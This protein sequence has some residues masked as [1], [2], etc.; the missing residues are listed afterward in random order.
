MELSEYENI[1]HQED[2]HF[3]YKANHEIII[4]LLELYATKKGKL[5]ILDAGCGT[6]LLAKKLEKFGEVVGVDYHPEAVKLSKSRGVKAKKADVTKLPFKKRG[7]DVV[8]AIDVIY[9]K[10][11]KDDT[12][13]LREFNR[14]LKCGG[15][16]LVRVPANKWL[17]LNHDKYVHT[18]ERYTKSE[19]AQKLHKAGFIIK[20]ISYVNGLLSL[21]AILKQVFETINPQS[22]MESGVTN[23]PDFINSF[24]ANILIGEWFLIKNSA[25]PLGL[26]LVAASYKPEMDSSKKSVL[27]KT[28][29]LL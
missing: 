8:V 13:A 23:T 19:L 29:P 20:Q 18:R 26:G 6:G 21:L 24:L 10:S 9:H 7:F 25:L 17:H 27:Q 16:L 22:S 12:K 14:V 5:K 2:K 1:Y 3:F 28:V 11:I 15:I 4:R